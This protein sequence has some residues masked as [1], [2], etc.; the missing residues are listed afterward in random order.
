MRAIKNGDFIM[1]EK[2]VDV[3]LEV[4]SASDYG[5]G[6]FIKAVWWNLGFVESYNMN[7]NQN[8]DIAKDVKDLNKKRKTHLNQWLILDE[9]SRPKCMRK[10]N[11]VK[12]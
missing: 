12:L 7:I 4:I 5:N 10:G 8:F 6:Y 1:H 11:W 2:L 3:C 9:T